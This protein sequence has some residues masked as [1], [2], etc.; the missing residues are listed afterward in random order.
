MK[1]TV[2]EIFRNEKIKAEKII[3]RGAVTPEDTMI[4]NS[5]GEFVT[6]SRGSAVLELENGDLINLTEG[7][8]YYIKALV[9]HRVIFTSNDCEWLCVY[10]ND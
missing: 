10:I 1:E 3:S 9:K 5:V 4:E 7:E 8:G 6:V 2:K